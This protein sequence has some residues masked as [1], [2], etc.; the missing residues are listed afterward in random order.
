MRPDSSQCIYEDFGTKIVT[1][2]TVQEHLIPFWRAI[3]RPW[4]GQQGRLW[5]ILVEEGLKFFLRYGGP[6]S[7]DW[8][9]FKN[10]V[11]N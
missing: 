4:V 8:K 2:Q 3:T 5:Y 11:E 10:Q 7:V 1:L 9:V 6:I